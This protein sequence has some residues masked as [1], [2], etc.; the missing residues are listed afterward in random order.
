MK[1][2]FAALGAYGHVYPLLPLALAC[3]DA[4]HEVVVATSDPF[5]DRLPLRTV[6]AYPRELTLNEAIDET[7]RRHPDIGAEISIVMFADVTAEASLP[8]MLETLTQERP[9]L[10]VTEPLFVGAAIAANLLQIPTVTFAISL[11]TAFFPL[12][13][14]AA[15]AYHP[16]A[17]TRRGQ[18]PPDRDM[19]A[20][21]L[22]DVCPP[23]LA[24]PDNIPRIPIRTVAHQDGTV[25]LPAWLSA[26]PTRP[27][28]Y[29]TLGTVSFGAVEVLRRTA[30][31]IAALDVELLIAVGPEGD[32]TLLG[33]LPD[34]VAVE[35]FVPQAEVLRHVDLAVH[36]GGTGTVLAV[37]EAGLPQVVLPQGADQ[38]VNAKL[39]D[40]VGAG[41]SQTN[42][43]YTPGSIS[44][45]IEP[46]LGDCPERIT[47]DRI[48]TEIAA[49]PAPAD[50]VPA[51]VDRA[52]S[53]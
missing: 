45:L 13:H 9:D 26:P 17:W 8:V 16:E 22:I 7:R 42:E 52:F 31:E 1:V 19:L 53:G 40:R 30:V 48:A 38:P 14:R 49:M 23:S 20:D 36:H 51:L 11:T 21:A 25:G 27:R 35:R 4:G 10:V 15:V 18:Q 5:L 33:P 32:P 37:L 43:D 44:A 41:R 29:L 3:R 50:V 47:A 28:V 46:L 2:V 12:I 6:Q 39:I 34:N 24:V